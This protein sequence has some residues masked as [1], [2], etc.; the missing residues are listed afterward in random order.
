MQKF[1]YFKL[2][3][4]IDPKKQLYALYQPVANCFLHITGDLILATQLKFLLSS[5]YNVYICNVSVAENFYHNIIDNESCENWTLSNKL[6]I[7]IL[8][9]EDNTIISVDNLVPT[10]PSEEFN[11]QQEKQWIFLC[12][13]WAQALNDRSNFKSH[14]QTSFALTELFNLYHLNAVNEQFI[15]DRKRIM[16]LLYLETDFD[17]ADQQVIKLITPYIHPQCHNKLF[18]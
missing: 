6:D 10:T 18:F 11:I 4:P 14:Y 3:Y 9:L 16:Q 13:H 2:G 7:A 8:A 15:Q 1:K 17:Q 12:S 5:K